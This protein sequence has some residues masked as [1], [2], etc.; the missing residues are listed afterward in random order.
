[1][2]DTNAQS[3][4]TGKKT[5]QERLLGLASVAGSTMDLLSAAEDRR[6]AQ[7]SAKFR[8]AATDLEAQQLGLAA[9]QTVGAGGLAAAQ[10][11]GVAG[12]SIE[13]QMLASAGRGEALGSAQAATALA[14]Q[15]ALARLDA[16]TI[17]G[18]ALQEAL[19]MKVKAKFGQAQAY[20]DASAMAAQGRG[21]IAKSAIGV[22]KSLLNLI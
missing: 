9:E 16:M 18:N 17:R 12:A 22:G 2:G 1:M 3:G 11:E 21:N 6:T 8:I 7:E 10:Q 19:G 13:N 14:G 20:M 5:Y 15:A 4:I